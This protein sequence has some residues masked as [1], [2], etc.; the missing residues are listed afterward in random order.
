LKFFDFFYFDFFGLLCGQR[1]AARGWHEEFGGS[2]VLRILDGFIMQN[3][4]NAQKN[5]RRDLFVV[6]SIT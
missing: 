4:P 3:Y 1:R 6:K 5:K 2:M